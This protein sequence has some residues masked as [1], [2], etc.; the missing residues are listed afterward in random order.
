LAKI[1]D[2]PE[3]TG[4]RC[5][6]GPEY[7][8]QHSTPSSCG[9]CSI[10]FMEEYQSCLI[11]AGQAL[12][13]RG[14]ALYEAGERIRQQ[15]YRDMRAAV[16]RA[17]ESGTGACFCTLTLAVRLRKGRPSYEWRRTTHRVK[18]KPRSVACR[19]ASLHRFTNDLDHAYVVW[20]EGELQKLRNIWRESLSLSRAIDRLLE[21]NKQA[22]LCVAEDACDHL[23]D[24]EPK[25]SVDESLA[26]K[27]SEI[28][29]INRTKI[30]FPHLPIF[31]A[32]EDL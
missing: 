25:D 18:G 16:R 17:N 13:I 30:E 8:V 32:D 22:G 27:L 9:R 29:S 31:R 10:W 2:L 26:Q 15:Y 20:A 24:L 1:Y 14:Q 12:R 5:C 11:N 23:P 19:T 3:I 28:P 4:G 21:L 6:A 7:P